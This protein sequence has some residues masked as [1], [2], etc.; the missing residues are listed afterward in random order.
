M[1]R[2]TLITICI[3]IL[4]S[5][6]ALGGCR[7]EKPAPTPSV[8]SAPVS[9]AEAAVPPPVFE[10]DLLPL[11]AEAYKS[12]DHCVGY[13]YLKNAAVDRPVYKYTYRSGDPST[14]KDNQN[15]YYLERNAKGKMSQPG[16]LFADFRCT[17]DPLPKNLVI[18]G[19][20]QKDGSMFGK[21]KK[22]ESLE[23]FNENPYIDFATLE[24]VEKWKI[25]S[26][27]YTDIDFYYIEPNPDEV[28]F[29]KIVDG[30]INRSEYII[31]VDV[32]QTDTIITLST[33]TTRFSPS[34]NC[35][36]VIM[37]R[38]LRENESMDVSPATK[39][40]SPLRPKYKMK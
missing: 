23:F 4:L 22:Y 8:T 36:F 2:I 28:E 40:P 26:V 21:L 1:K 10:K 11:A 31:N 17:F 9:S 35:R 12:N 6:C 15:N 13:L 7:K 27:F 30:A 16:E 38:K 25:F 24:K 29:K 20:E 18:Y 32:L 34:D 3:C 33:C 14:Y 19:H 37:G 39:N 5:A